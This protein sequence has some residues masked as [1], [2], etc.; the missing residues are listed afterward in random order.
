MN[1]E[2][3]KKQRCFIYNTTVIE[4]W[5]DVM[6]SKGFELTHINGNA[7]YFRAGKPIRRRHFL[8]IP[9][10]GANSESWLF[11][12][13]L[14]NGGRRIPCKSTGL[15]S[16]RLALYA[17]DGHEGQNQDLI[18][19]YFTYRNYRTS[20]RLLRN[21]LIF[22]FMLILCLVA[23]VWGGRAC[24][25]VLFPYTLFSLL[26]CLYSIITLAFF[27]KTCNCNR[28]KELLTRPNRPLVPF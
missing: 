13:F 22:C 17:D 27:A 20:K 10:K 21:I 14:K 11:Y 2:F 3:V 12:D 8:L 19:Y 18:D 7:Y 25:L 26:L 9:E 16:P 5:L 15:A 24:M 1:N 4:H 6:A 23:S 28:L